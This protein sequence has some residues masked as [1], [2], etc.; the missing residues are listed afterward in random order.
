MKAA[1]MSKVARV[2]LAW[3]DAVNGS[4]GVGVVPVSSWRQVA[5]D[6][7]VN[8]MVVAVGRVERVADDGPEDAGRQVR[9]FRAGCEVHSRALTDRVL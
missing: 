3:P 8:V 9:T 1:L 4:G 7:H 2:P 5:R 6:F